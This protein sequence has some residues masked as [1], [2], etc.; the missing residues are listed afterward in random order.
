[1]RRRELLE[2]DPRLL[3]EDLDERL[4]PLLRLALLLLRPDE[5]LAPLLRLGAEG[6]LARLGLEDRELDGRLAELLLLPLLRL[7]RAL[8]PLLRLERA[9]L[10]L[11]R[12]ERALLPL[13][14]LER[15]L[16]P[17]LRLERVLVPLL[18]RLDA[19]PLLRLERVL[20]PLL[21]VERVLLPLLLVE[22]VLLPLLLVERVLLPLLLVE[23][24]LVPLLLR[25]VDVPLER[26]VVPELRV[27]LRVVLEGSLR[28]V[29][30]VLRPSEE[31][32]VV[33]RVV[34]RVVVRVP[35]LERAPLD[36][37]D[38][39]DPVRLVERPT[40]REFVSSKEDAPRPTVRR[41]LAAP[42][43]DAAAEARDLRALSAR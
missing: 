17:L 14:R 4:A 5:R 8:L 2:L 24:V 12:L 16:L 38:L 15:A 28:V 37:A 26:R 43:A 13:L 23:R 27:V 9:L 3:P 29:R 20:L 32:V 22:R 33:E 21:L 36:V 6:L 30:V 40:V 11:L 19:D 34:E 18:L 41:P 39:V 7:E 25:L 42:R 31:R 35:S 10:P 1:M